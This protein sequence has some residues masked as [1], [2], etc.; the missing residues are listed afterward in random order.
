ERALRYPP[1]ERVAAA[2]R[3]QEHATLEEAVG[4][5]K[6]S[7]AAQ[8]RLLGPRNPD[9]L[10]SLD[11]LGM[12]LYVQG[13]FAGAES[14]LRRVVEG[15]RTVFGP[16][17]P[18]TLQS[19]KCLADS[20]KARGRWDAAFQ[21]DLEVAEGHRLTYGPSHVQTSGAV[22]NL[23]AEYRKVENGA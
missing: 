1:I 4:L 20:L 5:V 13:D 15:R 21:L 2:V 6:K 11:T 17:H 23:L 12:L 22:D 9:T 8:S 19:Q 18:G 14:V 3:T 16:L 7:Y 10:E